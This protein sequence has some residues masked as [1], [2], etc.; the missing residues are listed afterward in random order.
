LKPDFADAFNNL[1]YLQTSRGELDEAMT[2]LR[3]ALALKPHYPEAL[4]N[5]GIVH[6]QKHQV[7]EAARCF[8]G[9][10]ALRPQYP[11]ALN[12][13]GNALLAQG[14]VAEAGDCYRQALRLRPH[15]ARAYNN[16]AGVYRTLH[17]YEEAVACLR[18]SLTYNPNDAITH[19][20]LGKLLYDQRNYA[21]AL[22]C[23]QRVLTLC[24][25]DADARLFAEALS[26]T[27]SLARVP[28]DFLA[29][30][31]DQDADRF[32]PEIVLPRNYRS[33]ELLKAALEPAPAPRSLAILD[34][35]CGTGL[36]GVQFRDW[37]KT[38]IGVDLSANMLA[39]AREKGI[40]DQ[41]IVS[42]LLPAVQGHEGQFDLIV[43]SDV[44]LYFGDLEPLTQAVHRALRPGGRFAFN[45]DLL[46]EAGADYR[47]LPEIHFAHSRAYLQNLAARTQLEICMTPAMFPRSTGEEVA[48][49]V[50]VLS[51]SQL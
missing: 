31:Y 30:M 51:R 14:Q 42:D 23:F 5:L 11:E 32:E 48:G 17:Q 8:R 40:Y 28:A 4:S 44:V 41:L 46:D 38:L 49:L 3:R 6:Y 12:N 45:V 29:T 13:L 34:L 2:S 22:T 39:K 50:V 26:G 7:D 25:D 21:E 43:A 18:E 9:A 37:A 36:C 20:N 33:P 19:R 24:P 16:L 27:S 47:L 10:L 15:D 1:G 35:G